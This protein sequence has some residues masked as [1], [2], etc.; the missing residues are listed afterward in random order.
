MTPSISWRRNPAVRPAF[1]IDRAND[2]LISRARALDP[3]SDDEA[4]PAL[5]PGILPSSAGW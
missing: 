4:Q 5:P 3:Q 1:S 2:P